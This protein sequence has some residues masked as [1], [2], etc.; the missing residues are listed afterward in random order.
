MI[1]ILRCEHWWASPHSIN[2]VITYHR[3]HIIL[4]RLSYIYE[5]W[6]VE[7]L[8]NLVPDVIQVQHWHQVFGKTL[9]NVLIIRLPVIVF[10]RHAVV[11]LMHK[12]ADQVVDN[13]DVVD[14][15]AWWICKYA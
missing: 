10:Y 13:Y 11:R 14:V 3:R 7:I 2:L 12:V 9:Q 5:K 8:R 15:A 4:L 6:Q 1:N